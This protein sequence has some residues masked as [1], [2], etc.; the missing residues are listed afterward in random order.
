MKH[1]IFILFYTLI[2]NAPGS[3]KDINT[4]FGLRLYEDSRNHFTGNF[5]N[6]TKIKK[7]DS[8]KNFFNFV[9]DDVPSKSSYFSHYVISINENFKIH[10]IKGMSLLKNFKYCLKVKQNLIRDLTS[11]HNISFIEEEPEYRTEASFSTSFANIKSSFG[12]YCQTDHASNN[13]LL[14][15]L[16]RTDELVKD[17]NLWVKNGLK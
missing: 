8:I 16:I 10:Q 7:T 14:V 3:S 2:F 12:V 11:I 5:I 13:T 4:L 17:H 15:T 6:Q 1:F 9:V